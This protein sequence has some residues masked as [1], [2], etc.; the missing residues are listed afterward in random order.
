MLRVVGSDGRMVKLISDHQIPKSFRNPGVQC[1][2]V[3]YSTKQ[4]NPSQDKK[5]G[6]YE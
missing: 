3:R 2:R 6:V 4:D 1:I 5:C